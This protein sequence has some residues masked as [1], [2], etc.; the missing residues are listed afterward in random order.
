MLISTLCIL[1]DTTSPS[2]D[3][4]PSALDRQ[5]RPHSFFAAKKRVYFRLFAFLLGF[6]LYFRGFCLAV[7]LCRSKPYSGNRKQTHN[8]TLGKTHLIGLYGHMGSWCVFYRG[9][10]ETWQYELLGFAVLLALCSLWIQTMKTDAPGF[11]AS[12][13]DI[14]ERSCC[15]LSVALFFPSPAALPPG[16]STFSHVAYHTKE[17]RFAQ[18]CRKAP[19]RSVPGAGQK[20]IP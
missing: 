2:C 9:F 17:A 12:A 8:K 19:R 18:F 5:H 13:D 10:W 11:L 7:T 4:R 1:A 20:S 6:P 14:R 3:R 15:A 16:I